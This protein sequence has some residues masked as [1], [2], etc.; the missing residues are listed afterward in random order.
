VAEVDHHELW[1]RARLTA[2]CTGRTVRDVEELLDAAER[3]LRGQEWE[4]LSVDRDVVTLD[5]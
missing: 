4:V 2:A 3:Y 5:D 1:Q